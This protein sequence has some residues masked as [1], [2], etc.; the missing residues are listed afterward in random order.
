LNRGTS[1]NSET[2]AQATHPID[3]LPSAR[4]PGQKKPGDGK[5]VA[6]LF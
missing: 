1:P 5:T 3:T 2:T 4:N 6:R